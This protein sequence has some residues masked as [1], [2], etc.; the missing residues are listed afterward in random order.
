MG[1]P[2]RPLD[3][4]EYLR[5]GSARPLK[6][7]RGNSKELDE[8]ESGKVPPLT[9][10][11]LTQH[12]AGLDVGHISDDE[13]E[14]SNW[15]SYGDMPDLLDEYEQQIELVDGSADWNWRQR[16]VHQLIY[17]RGHYPIFPSWWQQH[18]K[19]WG[20]GL[21]HIFS[22]PRSKK[23]VLISGQRNDFAGKS[24]VCQA[25]MEKMQNEQNLTNSQQPKPWS[26]CSR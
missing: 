22:P 1:P 21:Q 11:T 3:R 20:I 16:K 7:R 25:A 2:P 23:R 24:P 14:D 18:V 15:D 9:E 10:S 13:D 4:E 19:M 12:A 5:G 6:R 17:M 26:L 8:E